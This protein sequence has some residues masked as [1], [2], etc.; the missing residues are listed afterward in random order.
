[1][2]ALGATD[3]EASILETHL[4]SENSLRMLEYLKLFLAV[5]KSLRMRQGKYK[6]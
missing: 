6:T 5:Q 2:V 1:M 4:I 3:R